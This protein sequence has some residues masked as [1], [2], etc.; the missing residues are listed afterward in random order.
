MWGDNMSGD[1]GNSYDDLVTAYGLPTTYLDVGNIPRHEV[2]NFEGTPTQFSDDTGLRGI[3]TRSGIKDVSSFNPI[4]KPGEK[5]TADTPI[6]Q[7]DEEGV[8][9]FSDGEGVT[10]RN[11][12]VPAIGGTVGDQAYMR[13][14]KNSGVFGT[15]GGDL[16]SA[17]KD[18]SFHKFL[19]AAAAITGGGLALNSMYGVGGL[20]A[21]AVASPISLGGAIPATELGAAGV[22]T[23]GAGAAGVGAAGGGAGAVG[24]G[25]LTA[26][27]TPSSVAAFEAGLPATMAD[28]GG[29]AGAGITPLKALQIAS[30]ARSGLGALAG[31][32][33]K[34]AGPAAALAAAIA[35]AKAGRGGGGSGLTEP[36]PEMTLD[37]G[38]Q[39]KPNERPGVAMGQQYLNPQYFQEGGL[40]S[41]EDMRS[42]QE[43]Q[44]VIPTDVMDEI[45]QIVND[46]EPVEVV[47]AYRSLLQNMDSRRPAVMPRF[48]YQPSTPEN[49]NI[50]AGNL[51]VTIPVGQGAIN[52]DVY[53]SR[54]NMPDYKRS[55][56]NALGLG[57]EAPL[58][59]GRISA[60]VNKPLNAPGVGGML[61]Y[62]RR[63][64]MGGDIGSR[65][66]NPDDNGDGDKVGAHQTVNMAPHY[67]MQGLYQGYEEGGKIPKL[68]KNDAPTVRELLEIIGGDRE[69]FE[70]LAGGESFNPKD[71]TPKEI[72][73]AKLLHTA[74]KTENPERYLESLNP[75][76]DSQLDYKLR[77]TNFGGFVSRKEPN[78]AVIRRL[79][80][81]ESIVPHELTHTL[82]LRDAAR[83]NTI[84]RDIVPYI[85]KL[86][87]E[88]KEKI[89][90]TAS[91]R[92]D[93]PREIYANLN[94]YA[95]RRNAAGEDFVNSPEGRELLPNRRMQGQYYLNT[96][97][98]IQSIYGYREDTG[99]KFKRN[100]RDS[101]F[102][103]A[104]NY[105]KHKTKDYAAGGLSDL[106][107]YSDG[108][109]M[110]KGPGDGM[111]DSIPASI[112]NKRPARLAT[113]EF[114]VPAD[115]VSHLGNGSSDAGA[116]VLYSMMDRVRQARTGQKK[117][118]KQINP[119]KFMPV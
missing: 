118:G 42:Q 25:S 51:G 10:R 24:T 71:Y 6:Q 56:I 87:P 20:G 104:I 60:S 7:V 32:L 106:G 41:L 65:Y 29:L 100:Q 110:L 12:G 21:G 98:G 47:D 101:Y 116:K 103:Q 46:E 18:P 48:N 81:S 16:L 76:H 91:N 15:I 1:S 105:I 30:L 92:F 3:L 74:N 37:W 73:A 109:R 34:V 102:D 38:Y 55:G 99:E 66:L 14:I 84:S 75:F 26:G 72:Q 28:I 93:N 86:S 9:L 119:N 11:T 44:R 17:A 52:A 94:D 57:Y 53:G 82:Q 54:M 96:M 22:G 49:P 63:F 59:D 8:L 107:A 40:S 64:A 97:P 112:E 89:F 111:S 27:I 45:R 79:A 35:A 5:I 2:L 88:T 23:A 77:D 33:G 31:G 58:G 78:T 85:E 90:G 117:Q 36:I 108:G 43:G 13:E 19:A 62:E 83:G 115:V 95:M 114:V 113:D 50:G 70:R 68:D 39:Y 80:E 67:P 61:N 4:V 69:K